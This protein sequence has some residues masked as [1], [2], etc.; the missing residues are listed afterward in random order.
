MKYYVVEK[1]KNPGIYNTWA[2]CKEQTNGFKGAIFK[3]YGNLKDAEEAFK[4]GINY[5]GFT[6]ENKEWAN[7]ELNS[8]SVD[9]AC[10]GNPGNGEY[11]IVKT[12]NKEIV[13]SSNMFLN[14][15]NNIMEFFALIEA[16]ILVKKNNSYKVIYSDS[17]SAIAWVKNKKVKKN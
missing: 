7:V 12:S 10:S 15:T 16:L 8:L 9:G 2:K 13:K 6:E 3:S 4:Y 11:R 17:V 1:G 14:T 5:S